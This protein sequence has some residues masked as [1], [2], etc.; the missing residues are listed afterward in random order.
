MTTN[1]QSSSPVKGRAPLGMMTNAWD[2]NKQDRENVSGFDLQ[3]VE[4]NLT[5]K[6]FKKPTSSVRTRI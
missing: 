1:A 3:K 4:N 6:G 5:V 2:S